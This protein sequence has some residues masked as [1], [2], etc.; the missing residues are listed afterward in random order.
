MQKLLIK[1]FKSDRNLVVSNNQQRIFRFSIVKEVTNSIQRKI[2]EILYWIRNLLRKNKNSLH[3]SC[4][5]G[6]QKTYG[7]GY[8]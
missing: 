8:L 1:I 3:D 7:E 5:P 4:L 6:P 2:Y